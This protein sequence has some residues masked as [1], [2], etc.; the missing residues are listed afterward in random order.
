MKKGMQTTICR[1]AIA[2]AVVAANSTLAAGML[3]EVVVTAE[4][5]EQNL[6][7]A[8]I[9]IEALT[10]TAIESQ[11]IID[12]KS[13]FDAIPGVQGYEAPSSRGNVSFS[14]RGIGSGNPNSVSSD[15]ANAI[16]IDGVYLGKATG[17][18]VDAMD[19]ERIEVLK[20]PQGTLYGRNSIGGAINF[21]T[22]KPGEELGAKVKVSTGDYGYEAA[23]VRVDVPLSDNLGMAV[24]G[25][26]RKRDDLYDNSNTSLDGFE[27]LDRSGHRLSL[28]FTPSEN[29]AIDYSYSHDELDEHSQMMDVVGFN[30]RAP[31]VVAA[32]GFP[33]AVAVDSAERAQTVATLAGYVGQYRDFG[34]LPNLPQVQT[35]LGWANDFVAWTNDEL[36]SVN[37]KP[38]LGSSDMSSRSTNDVDAHALTISYKI[39][40]MG[41][42]GDVEFKSI[43]GTREA[44]N[45]NSAD[46]DG[47]NNANIITDLPLLT[48]GGLF[49]DTVVP[50][51][52]GIYSM[53]GATEFGLALQMVDAIEERG[54]APVF[55]NYSVT[56]HEQFS[57][58]LQMVGSTDT[59]DYAVGLYYYDDE[60]SFRNH[61]IAS[62]PLATSD[63]SS[64][65][66]A[67]EATSVYGQF[68]YRASEE[69][70]VAITAGLRYTEETKD[71][72]YLW[73]GYNSNFINMFYPVLLN[74]TVDNTSYNPNNNYVT[75]EEAESLPERAGI[76]GRKFSEDFSN[77]SGRLT[78]Q[79]DLSDDA[80]IYA[81]YSTGYRSG[82]FNGDYFD[83]VNDSADAFNEEEIESMELGYKS[84]FWDGRAQLNAAL[85]SYDYTDLQ[86]S[87]V[88]TE[89]SK[90]TSAIA[91]AGSASR[92]GVEMSL[93]VAPTD[94][95]LV[96]LAWSHINGDFDE[97][98]A[99]YG[100]PTDGAA[101]LPLNNVA[102]RA[103]VP[104]DSF[105]LGVDW[106]IME[107]GSNQ[108]ALSI[109][110][111]Y[112]DETV[113]IPVSTAVYNTNA[114][115]APDTPVAYAQMPNNE[116]T[117]VNARLSWTKALQDSNVVVALWGKNLLDEDYR[118]FG[119]NYGEALGLNLHQ[120]GEP[121]TFGLD[122]TWEM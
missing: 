74:P 99:V 55:N 26:T 47:V 120:Y 82:G 61:R 48:I 57:Q 80:N 13:L 86:V 65:D 11:G 10:E 14:L 41:A 115:P 64:H 38:G 21:I 46:L 116:R 1:T 89:G 83:E 106:N 71:V 29:L 44:T 76:Y 117:I 122:F 56:D 9:S 37:S 88:L 36:S 3:E 58:E 104:D 108:L 17:N 31:G 77:L 67:A 7:D 95:L 118:N 114:N 87:T 34:L 54:N 113:S 68:T 91:N 110:A 5:R 63:T 35:Y 4:K 51:D 27:N 62:F 19:L 78:V 20:G 112:Q 66:V 28:R 69:S 105:N 50:N 18:G 72:T 101:V 102:Q 16:Y 22:K 73:R 121:A 98:P 49:L 25:Y 43:T 32:A 97:Y 94:N 119:F 100:S 70:K 90:V 6:Q 24:S 33:S 107:S 85:Y 8:P 96:S 93:R 15:P 103:M 52:I 23:N 81:T 109:S 40:D 53:D 84:M 60:S 2:L 45:M 59:L 42:F 12:I 30:P 79:Y 75:N 92:D 111:A 39:D